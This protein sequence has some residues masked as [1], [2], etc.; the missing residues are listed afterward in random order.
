MRV[1]ESI[2]LA[3]FLV[4]GTEKKNY[5]AWA[6]STPHCPIKTGAAST[7]TFGIT[8]SHRRGSGSLKALTGNEFSVHDL[9][10]AFTSAQQA[11]DYLHHCVAS[12]SSLLADA[13]ADATAVATAAA[14]KSDG[15]WW[16][17]YLNVF[18]N[19]LLFVHSSIEEPLKSMGITQTWGP[20]IAL[21][22]AGVRS[23]LVPL[24]IQQSK[25]AEYMK[26]LKPYQEEIKKKFAD[27]KEVMNRAIAKLY[28]DAGTN[29]LAGCLVSLAQLPI[30]IGLYRS[31]T[32]LAK[33]GRL[34]EPFLWIPSLEGPVSPP[35]YRG[36]DWLI[37]GWTTGDG[38]PTP[39]L[40]WETTLAFL[41][42]PV[43]LVL[44][45]SVSMRVLQPPIDDN[46]SPEEKQNMEK[47]QTVLKF[48]PLMI[49]Y[50][51]LQVPAGLT[52]YWL[53][54][55]LYTLLQSVA[56]K[57]YYAANPPKIELPEYWGS[58]DNVDSMTPEER[59]AAAEAGIS[60][61]PKFEDLMDE[62]RFHYVVERNPLREGSPAW[63]RVRSNGASIPEDMSSWVGSGAKVLSSS[64][65]SGKEAANVEMGK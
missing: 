17:N 28:E 58:L 8:T 37:S 32:L 42:M 21:F 60:T 14:T 56:V 15:G 63:D 36:L 31:I 64:S 22:T 49:G 24:S 34:E 40:G 1:A 65:G 13:A 23:A 50:F 53:T 19:T 47:S 38:L 54:S 16:Q 39:S 33:E 51:S 61:G 2:F 52:I 7:S 57:S 10:A 44:T 30:F 25:S 20:A 29:P 6:F 3:A 9:D 43:V 48:L 46:M 45:Q 41:V 55:N 18:K 62:A 59:R 26:A 12:S 5:G 35:T 11:A 27:R 4:A